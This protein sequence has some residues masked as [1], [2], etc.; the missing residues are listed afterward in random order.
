M[1]TS[2]A[3]DVGATIT[4]SINAVPP[5]MWMATHYKVK[6]K[7][8]KEIGAKAKAKAKEIGMLTLTTMSVTTKLVKNKRFLTLSQA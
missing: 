2:I 6:A 7:A 1:S 8:P 3:L 5:R 4:T